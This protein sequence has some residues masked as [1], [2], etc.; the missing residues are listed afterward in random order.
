MRAPHQWPAPDLARRAFTARQGRSDHGGGAAARRRRR[1]GSRRAGIRLL[2][3]SLLLLV[4]VVVAVAYWRHASRV[5]ELRGRSPPVTDEIETV[6]GVSAATMRRLGFVTHAKRSSF[7]NSTMAKPPGVTRIGAFGDSHTYGEEVD[8]RS[9]FP[10]Q[11]GDLLAQDGVGNVEVLNF[12]SSWHGFHQ[13]YIMWDEVASQYELDAVL[14]GPYTFWS[15]HETRLNHTNDILPYYLHAR[16]IAE[17]DDAQ[18][19]EV[20][21]DSHS[22]RFDAYHAFLTPWRY[23]RYDR[24]DPAFL[25]ALLPAGQTLG[26]PFY[27]DRRPELAEATAINRVLLGRMIRAGRPIAVG[28][29]RA[30][31]LQELAEAVRDL[32]GP[33]FCHFEL[34]SADWFPYVAP[35]GQESPARHAV[36]ARQYEAVL[37]GRPLPVTLIR[38]GDPPET[39]P[40]SAAMGLDGVQDLRIVAAGHEIGHL[41]DPT[42]GAVVDGAAM[43]DGGRTRSLLIVKSRDLAPTDGVLLALPMP[44][45]TA[46]RLAVPA[47]AGLALSSRVVIHAVELAPARPLPGSTAIAVLDLPGLAIDHSAR[48]SADAAALEAVLG[49]PIN[50]EV[51]VHIGERAVLRG[52]RAGDRIEL[53]PVDARAY[54]LRAAAGREVAE[55]PT[56]RSGMIELEL[57]RG[58]SRARVPLARWWADPVIVDPAAHCPAWVPPL[59]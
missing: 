48:L 19:V 52:L 50:D 40:G 2:A 18:M 23:L 3:A 38:T 15:D 14:L 46:T 8:E 49:G 36:N 27:Y 11:L 59:R 31:W 42:T 13:A 9:D 43:L 44:L 34:I 10:G 45:A 21:G 29:Y 41:V 56:R 28:S 58:D 25:A 32:S 24:N 1:H 26:N 55:L 54:R 6:P 39:V 33:T 16:F 47:S 17:G 30:P 51:E 5:E 4:G 35:R 37:R 12:G 53:Q 22:Q 7:V 20:I 57:R